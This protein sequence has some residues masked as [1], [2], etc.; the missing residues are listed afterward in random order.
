[1]KSLS[2]NIKYLISIYNKI[3]INLPCLTLIFSKR[4]PEI[5]DPL[6]LLGLINNCK[7]EITPTDDVPQEMEVPNNLWDISVENIFL[8]RPT[9]ASETISKKSRKHVNKHI[10]L[11][12]E[13]VVQEKREKAKVK[14][15]KEEKESREQ[16]TKQTRKQN[17]SCVYSNG[18]KYVQTSEGDIVFRLLLSGTGD[19]MT[20]SMP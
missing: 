7:L 11:T 1:M 6:L 2:I 10:V 14:E 17:K 5:D 15:E 20:R 16:F 3:S 13:E 19:K 18:I 9:S 12:L 4:A 8:P